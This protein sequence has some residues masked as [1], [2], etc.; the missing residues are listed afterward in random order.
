[1][2]SE[3]VSWIIQ[4]VGV[5]LGASI[6]VANYPVV[7]LLLWNQSARVRHRQIF[8]PGTRPAQSS[9]RF[10]LCAVFTVS[11]TRSGTPKT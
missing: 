5:T 10:D 9:W 7:A 3:F 2:P 6:V 1:V 8:S 4:H 11:R